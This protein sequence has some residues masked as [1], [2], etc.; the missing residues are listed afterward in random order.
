MTRSKQKENGHPLDEIRS[1]KEGEKEACMYQ[2]SLLDLETDAI[3]I[4]KSAQSIH[5]GQSAEK[6]SKITLRQWL[7]MLAGICVRGYRVSA[8]SAFGIYYVQFLLYFDVT[9]GTASWMRTIEQ[10]FSVTIGKSM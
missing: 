9:H 7:L 8:S 1:L 10:I 3:S 5:E 2:S 6:S 4:S